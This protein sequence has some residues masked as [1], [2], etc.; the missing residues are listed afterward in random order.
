M[1][2]W[3][4]LL[5]GVAVAALGGGLAVNARS[6][7]S[8][9][10][11]AWYR[12]GQAEWRAL[13]LPEAVR[14]YASAISLTPTDGRPYIALAVLYEAVD[15]SDLAVDVLRQLELSNPEAA[16]LKCRLA[17]AYLGVEDIG[18]ARRLGEAAVAA[19]P[20]CARAH[21]VY[22]IALVRSRFAVSAAAVLKKAVALAPEDTGINEV[23]VEALAQQGEYAAAI[24]AGAPLA[25]SGSNSPRL[26]HH[27]GLA[28][29]RLPPSPENSR[30]AEAFLRR[31]AGMAPQWFEPNAE[32]GRMLRSQGQVRE[33]TRAFE[34]A[35]AV[36]PTVPGVAFNLAALYRQA[37]DP[38]AAEMERATQRL[39][40]GTGSATALRLRNNQ[41]TPRVESVLA[42]ARAEA[43]AG[44]Y[45]P[46]LH[47][48][49]SWLRQDPADLAVL[50]LYQE[51]DRSSRQR[52]GSFARPSVLAAMGSGVME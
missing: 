5:T 29:S 13:R 47:R 40:A 18:E 7:Y 11:D 34:A 25:E 4:R 10:S 52:H 6:G 27:L 51:L 41:Q 45:A 2:R 15:R 43:A 50:T 8:D 23:L 3:H 20:E 39:S 35:W 48:L 31:A 21:S 24:R 46:A 16:H 22:G 44:T 49:R 32:L 1:A 9:P 37:K 17:E 30:R 33:A 19:E 14:C 38:R 42:L 28:Y 26:Y 12:R 36:E